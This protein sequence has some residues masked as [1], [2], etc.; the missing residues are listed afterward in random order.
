MPKTKELKNLCGLCGKGFDSDEEY[1]GHTCE[2]T[3]VTPADPEHQ[4][5]E[6]IAIAES[7]RKRGE[8]RK[9]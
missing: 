1:C 3:G 2:K 8:E 5:P 6:F 4:G 7:A 9:K